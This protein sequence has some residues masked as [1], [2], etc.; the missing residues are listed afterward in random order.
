MTDAH[1]PD[2]SVT[3]S[4]F[5]T[6]DIFV[7][8]IWGH[9]WLHCF[10]FFLPSLEEYKVRGVTAA[11]PFREKSCLERLKR[12]PTATDECTIW[13]AVICH[14]TVA[15]TFVKTEKTELP[16]EQPVKPWLLN[17]DSRGCFAEFWLC[18]SRFS[19]KDEMYRHYCDSF[20]ATIWWVLWREDRRKAPWSMKLWLGQLTILNPITTISLASYW[21]RPFFWQDVIR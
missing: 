14:T 1:H 21:P 16:G 10:L 3:V 12:S 13:K 18:G 9:L 11:E 2:R 17:K 19:N 7:S 5:V 15:H 4:M 6:A 8:V 20:P